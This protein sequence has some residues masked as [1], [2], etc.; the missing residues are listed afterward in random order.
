MTVE[1]LRPADDFFHLGGDSIAAAQV[2][3]A[4]ERGRNLPDADLRRAPVE[5]L[6]RSLRPAVALVSAWVAQLATAL[7]VDP[8]LLATRADLQAFLRGDRGARLATG[9][10]NELVG[11][12]VRQLADG[13]AALALENAQLVLEA[14]PHGTGARTTAADGPTDPS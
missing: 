14:R 9:W 10:R 5:D 11:E 7:E 4:V 3:A 12:P 2:L 6:D 1:A 13:K 8:V